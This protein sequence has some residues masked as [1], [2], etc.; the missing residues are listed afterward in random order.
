MNLSYS[1]SKTGCHLIRKL[2]YGEITEDSKVYHTE[3]MLICTNTDGRM[4][5]SER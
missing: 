3:M 1:E 4:T 2:H 5:I